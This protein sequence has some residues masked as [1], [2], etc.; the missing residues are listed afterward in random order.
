MDSRAFSRLMCHWKRLWV[1]LLIGAMEGY[2]AGKALDHAIAGL[3]LGTLF[4]FF[5]MALLL[6]AA[7]TIGQ[8]RKNVRD[9]KVRYMQH[10]GER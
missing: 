10:L 1:V 4:T 5:V 2:Y 3:L 9:L 6:G 7:L 8:I